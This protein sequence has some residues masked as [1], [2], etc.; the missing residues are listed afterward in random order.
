[1]K[2]KPEE[3]RSLRLLLRRPGMREKFEAAKTLRITEGAGDE[4]VV[5]WN[6]RS[7]VDDRSKSSDQVN[8]EPV[9]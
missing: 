1:M 4:P 9:R 6:G 2:V 3:I 5:V 8:K 7:Y